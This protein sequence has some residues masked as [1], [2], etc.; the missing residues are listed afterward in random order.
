MG[1][2]SLP[3]PNIRN[4]IISEP[5]IIL[6]DSELMQALIQA[7]EQQMGSNI[8][9]LRG[10]AMER[11][12]ARFERLEETHRH[13][14]AAA[15]ENMSS[16]NQIHRAIL[17]VLDAE[18]FD[19]FLDNLAGAITDIL[20]VDA[21]RLVLESSLSD[22]DP[23]LQGL[24]GVLAVTEPGF[25]KDYL[26]RGRDH[27]PRQITL[28]QVQPDSTAIHGEKAEWIR[29]EACLLL[30]LGP[31]RLPGMLVFGAEDPHQFK[32]TQGTDLLS[33]FAGTFERAMRRW[34]S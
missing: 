27:E 14:I 25:I 17:T 22:D 12:K 24:N 18:T 32:P 9:D 16:T 5:G 21:T 13:V 7:D 30:D 10:A 6:D 11:Q 29:S 15:Y 33:F 19:E 26:T 34:L 23:A 28:R 2:Q 8:V 31:G 4:D 20:R 3:N 1:Q